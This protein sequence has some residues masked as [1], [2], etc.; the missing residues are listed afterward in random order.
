[1]GSRTPST[2]SIRACQSIPARGL[3]AQPVWPDYHQLSKRAFLADGRRVSA[4]AITPVLAASKNPLGG[5]R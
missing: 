4:A 5:A 3:H 1:M 2:V